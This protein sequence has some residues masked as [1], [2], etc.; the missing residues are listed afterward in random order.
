MFSCFF[1][2]KLLI[3]PAT[4]LK[5]VHLA[6]WSKR[7]DTPDLNESL[8]TNHIYNALMITPSESTRNGAK[9]QQIVLST[10]SKFIYFC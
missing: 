10:Q 9:K 1:V 7:L 4:S 8:I 3:R 5:F 6:L 2:V